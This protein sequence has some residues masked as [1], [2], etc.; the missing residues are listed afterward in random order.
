MGGVLRGGPWHF[1]KNALILQKWSPS[2]SQELE[3][4][5]VVPVWVLLPGLDPLFWSSSV[6]SKI[7]SKLGTPLYADRVTSTKERLGFARV[8]VEV[9]VSKPLLHHV[10]LNTPFSGGVIQPVEYEWIPYYCHTCKKLRHESSRCKLNKNKAVPQVYRPVANAVPIPAHSEKEPAE[11]V[12]VPVDQPVVD[13]AENGSHTIEGTAAPSVEIHVPADTGPSTTPP[14]SHEGK[15]SS[16]LGV[17]RNKVMVAGLLETRVKHANSSRIMNKFFRYRCSGN[18]S[19]HY[20]GR[21]WVLWQE[22]LV[23][24]D[25]L[26]V[27]DQ[28]VH[29]RVLFR[30]SNCSVYVTFMYGHN[31]GLD[32]KQLW[33]NLMAIS[34]SVDLGWLVIGDFNAVRGM[35]DKIGKHPPTVWEMLDFNGCLGHCS[36]AELP[37]HGGPFTWTNNQDGDYRGWS[38]LDWAFV[39]SLWVHLF[40]N[41]KVEILPAGSSDHSPLMVTMG[42]SFAFPKVFKFLNCWTAQVNFHSVVSRAWSTNIRGAPMFRLFAKLKS[43][44]H[45]LGELHRGFYSNLSARVAAA[46]TALLECQTDLMTSPLDPTFLHRVSEARQTY[47]RVK[48]AELSML[49]QRAKI[50]HLKLSDS[51]TSYFY[52]AVAARKHQSVITS[53]VDHHGQS[54]T[55]Q[56]GIAS[57]LCDYYQFLLGSSTDVS[58]LVP[59]GGASVS[60]EQALTL[61]SVI[62]VLE[63]KNALFSMRSNKS[64][65]LDGFSAEFFKA[66]WN[67]VS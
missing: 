62:V 4:L 38:K 64:P 30:Q 36:L 61:S 8:M 40:P 11:K 28:L 6:L 20:N 50:L 66:A 56:E 18:Y 34:A 44:K 60:A 58:A 25:V 51:N 21:I 55:S 1:G 67:I 5:S 29:C 53:I 41:S 59:V 47:T 37:S 33:H 46:H 48:E 52:A 35:K 9:D 12:A 54:H 24:L 23:A 65:R 10:I 16:K 32:R 26:E 14:P 2:I 13:R 7:S 49:A 15:F 42:V 57:A 45:A 17:G 27:H 19:A 39:N 43:V 22:S 31:D 3:C 63:I